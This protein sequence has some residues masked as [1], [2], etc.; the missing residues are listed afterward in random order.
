MAIFPLARESFPHEIDFWKKDCYSLHKHSRVKP[1]WSPVVNSINASLLLSCGFPAS[2]HQHLSF[3]K[4]NMTGFSNLGLVF[5]I[6]SNSETSKVLKLFFCLFVFF[7]KYLPL[8]VWNGQENI[9][10]RETSLLS[11]LAVMKNLEVKLYE[12]WNRFY[13]LFIIT[14]RI[15]T[16]AQEIKPCRNITSCILVEKSVQNLNMSTLLKCSYKNYFEALQK[17]YRNT[18]AVYCCLSLIQS[19][20]VYK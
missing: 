14:L 18:G 7:S 4:W 20:V 2:L 16:N 12:A 6:K 8:L 15:E 1:L 19:L 5:F 3:L 9:K 10:S 17:Q 11:G 13:I